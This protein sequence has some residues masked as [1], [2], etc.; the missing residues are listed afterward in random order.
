MLFK[1][2]FKSR[3]LLVPTNL[4]FKKDFDF[5]FP[6]IVAFRLLYCFGAVP[7]NHRLQSADPHSV[8]RAGT[9]LF[10]FQE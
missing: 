9:M 3:R 2:C 6:K 1:K 8:A 7:D 10:W 5:F 4:G